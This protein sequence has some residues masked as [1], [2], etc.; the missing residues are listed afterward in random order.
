[1]PEK[2]DLLSSERDFFSGWHDDLSCQYGLADVKTV[3]R[4]FLA[5]RWRL[6]LLLL[7]K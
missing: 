2:L 3:L 7:L 6:G 4:H 5:R 1:M